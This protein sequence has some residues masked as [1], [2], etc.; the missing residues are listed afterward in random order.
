MLVVVKAVLIGFILGA[1]LE[2][3]GQILFLKSIFEL[4]FVDI[5]IATP[6]PRTTASILDLDQITALA[7]S[8]A[9]VSLSTGASFSVL[10]PMVQILLLMPAFSTSIAER[11]RTKEAMPW[12][13]RAK[14]FLGKGNDKKKDIEKKTGS[15]QANNSFDRG[16]GNDALGSRNQKAKSSY[17]LLV[18]YN[19]VVENRGRYAILEAHSG[20]VSAITFSPDG[21]VLASGPYDRIRAI[22]DYQIL[23][24]ASFDQTIRL[25]GPTTGQCVWCLESHQG[26]VSALAFSHNSKFFASLAMTLKDRTIRL[27]NVDIK[28]TIQTIDNEGFLFKLPFS[29]NG[30]KLETNRGKRRMLLSLTL[31]AANDENF[32]WFPP[33]YVLRCVA[34]END[35]LA[36]GHNE[37]RA[38]FMEFFPDAVPLRQSTDKG[39]RT[40]ETVHSE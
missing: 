12:G 14:K 23:A 25:W 21:R 36:I 1:L 39:R 11:K 13:E 22:Q 28:E 38:T 7:L 34:F 33:G 10:R 8:G 9:L 20:Q 18:S 35:V 19:P 4:F 40:T 15:D 31:M 26:E 24:S 30:S 6:V 17:R 3:C 37:D 27:W 5:W 2:V 16:W 32:F 29:D